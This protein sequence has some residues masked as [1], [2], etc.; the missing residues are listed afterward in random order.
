[1]GLPR[2]EETGYP[3][4][5][6]PGDGGIAG[7]VYDIQIGG[8]ELPEMFIQFFGDHE[9]I[10][11]LPYGTVVQLVGLDHTVDGAKNILF[12]QTFDLHNYLVFHHESHELYE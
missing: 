2:A 10:Q 5:H 4:P 7:V 1:M 3:H 9:L 12:E 11:F 6:L 8:Q